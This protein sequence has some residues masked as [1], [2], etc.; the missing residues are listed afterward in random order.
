VWPDEIDAELAAVCEHSRATAVEAGD[1]FA[2]FRQLL[3]HGLGD[4][5]PFAREPGLAVYAIYARRVM[6][7][8]AVL[9]E[10]MALVKLAVIDRPA[11]DATARA[12]SLERARRLLNEET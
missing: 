7:C 10:A 5:R 3:R 6:M 1:L 2:R 12:V 8:V 9:G 4:R 11:D